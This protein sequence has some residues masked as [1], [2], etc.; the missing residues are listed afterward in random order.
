MS[1]FQREKRKKRVHLTSNESTVLNV[2]IVATTHAI[3]G[4]KQDTMTFFSFLF[5]WWGEGV[6]WGGGGAGQVL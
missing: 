2:Y 1:L 4:D 5:F 3:H 6:G